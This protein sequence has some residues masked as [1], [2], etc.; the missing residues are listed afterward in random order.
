MSWW[1]STIWWFFAVNIHSH[2]HIYSCHIFISHFGTQTHIHVHTHTHTHTSTRPHTHKDIRHTT[3]WRGFGRTS[4]WK[5]FLAVCIRVWD[6]NKW[7]AQ[8]IESRVTIH[9]ETK[10]S[11]KRVWFWAQHYF[12]WKEEARKG[13]GEKR[14]QEED[15]VGE[16][17]Y[18]VKRSEP[19]PLERGRYMSGF[20]PWAPLA[21]TLGAEDSSYIYIFTCL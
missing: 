15:E 12:G 18:N 9:R 2:T 21:R 4:N 1:E 3:H 10:A 5:V 17:A 19:V 16:N 11:K 13:R 20:L 7:H 6:K 8:E 14:S